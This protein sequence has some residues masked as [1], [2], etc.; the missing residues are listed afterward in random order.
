[1]KTVVMVVGGAVARGD[2]VLVLAARR[3]GNV[4]SLRPAMGTVPTPQCCSATCLEGTAVK[5]RNSIQ[6]PPVTLKGRH[7]AK[8]HQALEETST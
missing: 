5:V 6:V 3:R 2:S 4:H 8:D 1:M 7:Q